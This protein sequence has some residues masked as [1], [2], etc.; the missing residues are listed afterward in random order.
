MFLLA[1]EMLKNVVPHIG[2]DPIHVVEIVNEIKGMCLSQI[3]KSAQEIPSKIPNG[4]LESS[5]ETALF[6]QFFGLKKKVYTSLV[7]DS[8]FRL[9]S[10][11][12]INMIGITCVVDGNLEDSVVV[13][14]LAIKT[15][16][17]FG[18][19]K[20]HEKCKIAF[21]QINLQLA[22]EYINQVAIPIETD[23]DADY[24]RLI[25]AL[26]KICESGANVVLSTLHIGNTAQQYFAN[27]NIF[28]EDRVPEEDL[29]RTMKACGGV[30]KTTTN[31]LENIILGNC[32]LF[33]ERQIG[34]ERFIIFEGK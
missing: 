28:C 14:G 31:D 29:K 24:K 13:D 4:I 18:L 9:D 1:D 16:N 34:R 25:E 26:D 11:F 33:E 21:L 30:V 27:R 19:M 7:V 5:V 6:G 22:T 15:R 17:A 10:S 12:P 2:D 20:R 3:K 23:A 8:V 32:K